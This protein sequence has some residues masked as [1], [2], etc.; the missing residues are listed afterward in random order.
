MWL[1]VS[2]DPAALVTGQYFYHMRLRTPNPAARDV[3]RQE[4]LMA[5]CAHFSGVELPAK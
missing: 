2:D 3:E 5:A 4:M 1:A